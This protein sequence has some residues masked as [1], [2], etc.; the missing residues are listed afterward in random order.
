MPDGAFGTVTSLGRWLL[1]QRFKSGG[2]LRSG[3]E[4]SCVCVSVIVPFLRLRGKLGW[5]KDRTEMRHGPGPR[6]WHPAGD[7]EI[8]EDGREGP[9]PTRTCPW[10]VEGYGRASCMRRAP[11]PDFLVA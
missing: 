1:A 10:S 3:F 11:Q 5:G 2:A 8:G 9:H 7:Q 6:G 4:V